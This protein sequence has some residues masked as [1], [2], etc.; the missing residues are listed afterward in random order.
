MTAD[1]LTATLT[2]AIAEGICDEAPDAIPDAVDPRHR[3]A[4]CFRCQ[5]NAER[6]VLTV[7]D[8]IADAERAAARKALTDAA[9]EYRR[10]YGN[11]VVSARRYAAPWLRARAEEVGRDE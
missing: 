8:L 3:V 2:R 10:L 1:D 9:D 4:A 11:V 6:A 7:A 5:R